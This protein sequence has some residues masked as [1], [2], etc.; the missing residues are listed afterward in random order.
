LNVSSREDMNNAGTLA[1]P[2]DRCNPG[3][4]VAHAP[5]AMPEIQTMAG[6]FI[7]VRRRFASDV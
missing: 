1:C 5:Q 3:L 2:P 6:R 7:Y 4:A